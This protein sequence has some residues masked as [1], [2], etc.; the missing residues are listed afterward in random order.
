MGA[1]R[2]WAGSLFLGPQKGALR[3]TLI[4]LVQFVLGSSPHRPTISAEGP[5][6]C[7]CLSQ[8]DV[9]GA[10][11]D[12]PWILSP[13][14]VKILTDGNP[15]ANASTYGVGCHQ[16]DAALS[17]CAEPV[18]GS[19]CDN[20]VPS[21]PSCPSRPKWCGHEWCWVDPTRCTVN[22]RST[23]FFPNTPRFYSY[24][25][26]GDPNVF[27]SDPDRVLRGRVV[28]AGYRQNLGGTR[29]SYHPVEGSGGPEHRDDRWYGPYPEIV[30]TAARTGGFSLNIT[31]IPEHALLKARAHALVRADASG[32]NECAYAV[33]LG[34]LDLCVV[35][36]PITS[37]RR[38]LADF[39]PLE[40]LPLHLIVGVDHGE[41]SVGEMFGDVFAPY[42]AR[43]WLCLLV[44]ALVFS[45]IFALQERGLAHGERVLVG[46]AHAHGGATS[47]GGRVTGLG[48]SCFLVL[49]VSSYVA[50]LTRLYV[51]SAAAGS[52]GSIQQAIERNLAVCVAEEHA[53][54]MARQYPTL[55]I[56]LTP[57]QP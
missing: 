7:P 31:E 24:A 29:G 23:A 26:C 21:S 22:H 40:E 48:I 6:G 54:Q 42:S 1:D 34:Y 16:H 9:V 47:V 28:R 15:E 25:A 17:W 38:R 14:D 57:P 37:E 10:R 12:Q 45:A 49:V 51:T 39:L 33:G 20:V 11:H 8:A 56:T 3:A 55:T 35:R 44:A 18:E 53:T 41:P 19:S 46:G 2:Q 13:A 4:L 43:T 32:V 50:S 52:A 36:A 30:S 27:Y 5:S